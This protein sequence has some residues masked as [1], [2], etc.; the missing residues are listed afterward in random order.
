MTTVLNPKFAVTMHAIA[1]LALLGAVEAATIPATRGT[2]IE[3]RDGVIW[4]SEDGSGDVE[5]GVGG[6]GK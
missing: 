2:I 5:V 3:K 6:G 4:K 1:I